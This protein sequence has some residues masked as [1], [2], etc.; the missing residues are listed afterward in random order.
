MI[1]RGVSSATQAQVDEQGNLILFLQ[2]QDHWGDEF[3]AV[4]FSTSPQQALRYTGSYDGQSLANASQGS[5]LLTFDADATARAFNIDGLHEANLWETPGSS[6]WDLANNIP[7]EQNSG[8]HFLQE[9]RAPFGRDT[10]LGHGEIAGWV[11]GLNPNLDVETRLQDALDDLNDV[12]YGYNT[13]SFKDLQDGMP[14]RWEDLSQEQRGKF[15]D[16]S[17]LEDQPINY[18]SSTITIPAGKW[19]ATSTRKISPFGETDINGEIITDWEKSLVDIE[20][21]TLSNWEKQ[22]YDNSRM[23]VSPFY[24]SREEAISSQDLVG[25]AEFRSGKWDKELKL[26]RDWMQSPE[27][28]KAFMVDTRLLG[29]VKSSSGVGSGPVKFLQQLIFVNH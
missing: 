13:G 20:A 29:E 17:R 22:L 9:A 8:M 28:T 12:I 5:V 10:E 11:R 4:S 19:S 6:Y 21:E 3:G 1:Y 25:A 18:G 23:T 16:M 24:A 2:N 14:D 27:S 7:A 26:N 15:F